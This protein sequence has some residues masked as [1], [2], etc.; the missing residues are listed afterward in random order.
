M[1]ENMIDALVVQNEKMRTLLTDGD[2]KAPADVRRR[3]ATVLE[4]MFTSLVAHRGS[5]PVNKERVNDLAE[6]FIRLL[7]VMDAAGA[8]EVSMEELAP[9]VGRLKNPPKP[10][11]H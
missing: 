4:L 8:N 11:Q 1:A 2:G 10:T 9:V 7:E 3:E 5:G 6:A